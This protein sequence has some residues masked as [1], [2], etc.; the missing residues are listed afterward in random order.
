V[1]LG[2]CIQVRQRGAA[3]DV[4]PSSDGIDGHVSHPAEIDL[5]TVIDHAAPGRAVRSTANRD[6][7]IVLPSEADRGADT[8]SIRAANDDRRASIDGAVPDDAGLVVPRIVRNKHL[9]SDR[10]PQGLDIWADDLCH[11]NLLYPELTPGLLGGDSTFWP[12]RQCS[13]F[14]VR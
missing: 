9:S 1:G 10:C 5:E 3:T 7:E 6:F 2:G 8:G 11:V 4:R 12:A 14:H 13:G